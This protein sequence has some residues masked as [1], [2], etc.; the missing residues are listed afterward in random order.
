MG[1]YQLPMDDRTLA[2]ARA[3][4][5]RAADGSI[6]S[7]LHINGVNAALAY[8]EHR[9]PEALVLLDRFLA[10]PISRPGRQQVTDPTQQAP[11]LFMRALLDAGLLHGD[12]MTVTGKTVAA[13]LAVS[14]GL[15]GAKVGLL[16]ADIYGPSQSKLLSTE[17]MRPT[18]QGVISD[19]LVSFLRTSV[20]PIP[21]AFIVIVALTGLGLALTPS[22]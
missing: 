5:D 11:S 12:A 1:L 3:L 18:A 15:E 13:N 16:D 4:L 22:T 9:Y 10:P 6:N 2:M 21:I 17:G 14:F 7:N 19:D 20:G 8:R